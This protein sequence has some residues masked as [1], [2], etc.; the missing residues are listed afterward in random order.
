MDAG[1]GAA[2]K[3][4]AKTLEDSLVETTYLAAV[5]GLHT[6]VVGNGGRLRLKL[7]GFAHKLPLLLAAVSDGVALP[8]TVPA[9]SPWLE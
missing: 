4:L 3:L 7:E 2:L 8:A 5:A 6:S 9:G 1:E